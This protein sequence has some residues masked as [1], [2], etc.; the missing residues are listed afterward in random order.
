MKLK[1]RITKIPTKKLYMGIA[2]F[3]LLVIFALVIKGTH[4]YYSDAKTIPFINATI[5]NFLNPTTGN[6]NRSSDVNLIYYMEKEN[7]SNEYILVSKVPILGYT[8]DSENSNCIPKEVQGKVTYTDY[9]I[10]EEGKVTLSVTEDTPNQVVCRL[11]YKRDKASDITI[12][13]LIENDY[14]TISYD[15]KKYNY[16]EEIPNNEEYTYKNYKCD[17]DTILSYDETNGIKYTASKPDICY[18]Y[19]DKKES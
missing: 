1:E 7:N 5:G 2:I 16:V 12:Y 8:I 18:I 14:G 11:F 15:S 13:A 17:G 4:A 19:F 3:F 10:T 6:V 9:S